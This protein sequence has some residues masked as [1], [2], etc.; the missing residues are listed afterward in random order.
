MAKSRKKMFI[1]IGVA[2]IVVLF[3]GAAAVKA[4]QQKQDVGTLVKTATI[5]KQ[6][7]EAHILTS[8]EVVSME[9]REVLPDVSAKIERILVKEGDQVEAGQ[10]LV[11]LASGDLDY[12]MKEAEIKL[13]MEKDNL[14]QLSKE[15]YTEMEI[16]LSNAEI[17]YR[18][19]QTAYENNKKLYESGAVSKSELDTA[20][21]NLD[22]NYNNYLLAKKNLENLKTGSEVT[23]QEKQVRLSELAMEKI[24]TE[25]EKYIVKSPI[26]GTVT[27]VDGV[28]GSLAA[29]DVAI[30]KVVNTNSLEIVTNISEYD[31]HKVALGQQV[32]ITGDAFEG[33]EYKG[34][35]KYIDATAFSNETGQGKETVVKV[36][37][38]VIDKNTE[39]KPGFSATT[40]ILTERKKGALVIPYEAIYT[41]KNG[42]KVVFTIEKGKA[43]EHLVKTG[44]ESELA[45][46]VIANDLHEKDLVIM[47]PTEQLKD[48][49]PVKENK[50]MKND[51]N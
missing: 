8:G 31:I 28:E 15:N 17:Q 35:V 42:E 13:A 43:K 45:V 21:S 7:I 50:V 29:A 46:E 3:V 1:M 37:I 11:K 18:D 10:E 2:L 16:A 33:K 30:M 25:L 48:G 44:I 22:Q 36:K 9:K 41:K 19:A 27:N 49:D 34:T 32:K 39:L 4:S 5:E 12:Q 26:S 38:E 14:Q 6:D 51:K 20:K 24:G 47:N 23:A 40:D